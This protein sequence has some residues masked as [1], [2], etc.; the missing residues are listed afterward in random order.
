MHVSSG[1]CGGLSIS[2]IAPTIDAET[3]TAYNYR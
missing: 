3:C 1:I 2:V